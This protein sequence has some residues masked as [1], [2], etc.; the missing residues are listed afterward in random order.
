MGEQGYPCFPYSGLLP[1]QQAKERSKL[2]EISTHFGLGSLLG[3]RFNHFIGFFRRIV[4]LF[5]SVTSRQWFGCL[6]LQVGLFTCLWFWRRIQFNF[7]IA[8][9][10]GSFG[11][12]FDISMHFVLRKVYLYTGAAVFVRS[13]FRDG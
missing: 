8:F 6:V 9:G 12:R 1:A 11:L 10:A 4:P 2:I 13:S 3:N 5:Q 7:T